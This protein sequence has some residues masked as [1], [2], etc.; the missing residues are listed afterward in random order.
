MQ[1]SI[2]IFMKSMKIS[3]KSDTLPSIWQSGVD[4]QQIENKFLEQL[5][6]RVI[7]RQK[8]SQLFVSFF[9]SKYSDYMAAWTGFQN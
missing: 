1:D 8:Y 2:C 7:P 6:L 9:L 4:F 3:S 5:G